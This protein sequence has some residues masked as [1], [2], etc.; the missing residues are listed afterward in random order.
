MVS[1]GNEW[2]PYPRFL[3]NRLR[4]CP[5]AISKASMLTRQ[6]KR[7]RKRRIPCHCLASANNGSTQTLRL[8]YAF[9]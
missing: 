1:A 4:F 5:A 6:S 9:L 7:K 8:R 3:S 2:R